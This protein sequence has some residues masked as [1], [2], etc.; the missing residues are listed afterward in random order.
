[1]LLPE[2]CFVL[3]DG[4]KRCMLLST[5]LGGCHGEGH[6]ATTRAC[7]GNGP[8]ATLDCPCSVDATRSQSLLHRPS[9]DQS[10]RQLQANRQVTVQGAMQ[11]VRIALAAFDATQ[12]NFLIK[13]MQTHSR[14]SISSLSTHT[15][16]PRVGHQPLRFVR[17]ESRLAPTC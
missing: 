15:R 13:F 10:S 5:L 6:W 2:I 11:T 8:G 3:G 16:N 17:M 12:Y 1:M 9:G 14:F 7:S 4:W